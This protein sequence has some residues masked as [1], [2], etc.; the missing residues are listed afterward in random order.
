MLPDDAVCDSA[1]GFSWDT[2]A[3]VSGD[4]RWSNRTA[5]TATAIA[6]TTTRAQAILAWP[7]PREDSCFGSRKD[8]TR[9]CNVEGPSSGDAKSFEVAGRD[10]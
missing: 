3:G 10:S 2:A 1:E 4:P 9:W 6:S 5:S 7:D 8:K